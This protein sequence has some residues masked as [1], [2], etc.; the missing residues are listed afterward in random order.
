MSPR[1]NPWD[2][3]NTP[4]SP[5]PSV[6]PPVTI[7]PPVAVAPPLPERTTQTTLIMTELDTKIHELLKSQPQTPEEVS[8][9]PRPVDAPGRH[10]LSLPDYFERLSYDCT[11]GDSCRQHQK[12]RS[13]VRINQADIP[14]VT[15]MNPGKY[16]FRWLLKRDL[17]LDTA[18]NVQNWLLVNRT[19]SEFV[20]APKHLFGIHGAHECGDAVLAFMTVESALRIRLKPGD[21]SRERLHGQLTP[22]KKGRVLMTGNPQREEIHEPSW[23]N[24]DTE[25]ATGV[26][27]GTEA[28]TE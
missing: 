28:T 26:T 13:T 7:P 6:V 14:R 2:K 18:I 15:V 11:H 8:A 25:D 3:S 16:V 1:L 20:E 5:E 17:A 12:E 10:R 22:V 24:E 21:L 19:F 9:Q 27:Y 23:G 4:V